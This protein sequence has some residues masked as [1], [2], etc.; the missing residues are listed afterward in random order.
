MITAPKN[1]ISIGRLASMLDTTRDRVVQASQAA[2]INAVETIDQ[3]PFFDAGD[4]ER[5]RE[6]LRAEHPQR[7]P[8]H[9]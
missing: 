3:V 8:K 7:G 2:D 9:P 1:I 5:I 6:H 4:V